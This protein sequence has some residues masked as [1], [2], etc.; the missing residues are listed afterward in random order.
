M[1]PT[2]LLSF[3]LLAGS[4]ASKTVFSAVSVNGL[5]QGHGVGIR[6]PS[7][8]APITDLTSNDIICNTGISTPVSQTVIPV[9]AGDAI[10]AQ[11]HKS[12]LGYLGPDPSDP[13][14]PTNKGPVIAYLAK[15][16]S[17]T[18]T[19]VTGLQWFKIGQNGLNPTTHQ[20]GSDLLFANGGN[21]TFTVP[22]CLESGQYLFRAEAIALQ[23]AASYPGAQFYMSCAQLSISGP[24]SFKTPAT[25]SF[26]GA[27]T[28]SSPGIVSNIVGVTSYTVPGPDVFT[29]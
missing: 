25:V 15:V 10:T 28:P 12:P 27:Y 21:A 18:Q 11:F 19:T 5:S 16:P 22:S 24:T 20:W 1:Q 23:N 17:A 13:I 4:A 7:T 3:V 26:P 2:A 14:D 9:K 29:C 8:N 6:V